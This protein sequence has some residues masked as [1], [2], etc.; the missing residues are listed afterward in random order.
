[1]YLLLGAGPPTLVDTGS[2]V[3]TSTHHI[4]MG[5]ESVCQEFGEPIHVG[6]IRRIIISHGHTDHVGGLP[7][8]LALTAAQLAIH[9][10]D[11]EV[12]TSDREFARGSS[13]LR[14]FLRQAGVAPP[15]L[16]ALIGHA[17][18]I[19]SHVQG[20]TVGLKLSDGQQIDGLHVIH[21]PGHSPGHVC[22][23]VGNVLLSGDHILAQTI[24]QQWPSIV[25]HYAGL[26]CYLESLAKIE[27]MP[28]FT[29]TLAAH[30]QVI[31]N[32]YHRI[33][34]IRAA[35]E[36]RLER[37]LGL[38]GEASRPLTLEEITRELYPEVTGFRVVLAI[39][40][41]GSRVEYLLRQGQLA[42]ANPGDAERDPV[43]RYQLA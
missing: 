3:G 7:D 9:P 42:V 6:D 15:Q 17:Q 12:V 43:R 8:L 1:V 4:L 37:L 33:T 22:L 14:A 38:V 34:T 36:Q 5:V 21:T 28:G 2:G 25:S 26:G 16:E 23:G 18:R 39:T 24:P 32:V 11:R 41:V 30:E 13:S 10:L 19:G 29:L 40:D 31:H 20:L 27:R 35:I